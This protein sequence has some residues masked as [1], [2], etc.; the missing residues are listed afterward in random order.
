MPA[1]R[2][3]YDQRRLNPLHQVPGLITQAA[4]IRQRVTDSHIPGHM[5]EADSQAAHI[6]GVLR[7][8]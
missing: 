1:T 3:E 4:G 2:S 7:S 6:P 5:P 8:R